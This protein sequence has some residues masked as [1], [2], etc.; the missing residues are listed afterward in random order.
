MA[1]SYEED[2]IYTMLS[3]SKRGLEFFFFGLAMAPKLE[4]SESRFVS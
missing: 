1:G 3:N 2:S 4:K